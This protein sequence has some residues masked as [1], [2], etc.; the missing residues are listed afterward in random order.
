M[1]KYKNTEEQ[2]R[3]ITL[4]GLATAAVF[5]FTFFLKLPGINGYVHLGD[6]AIFITSVILPLPYSALA[7]MLGAGLADLCGGYVL[8]FPF[9]AVI[10]A[11]M[12]LPFRANTKRIM[13]KRNIVALVTAVAMNA[14][15]YYLG[16][17]VI[18]RN[19]I[20]PIAEIPGNLAQG[21]CGAVIFCAV[22]A[23][24]DAKPHLRDLI[25]HKKDR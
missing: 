15:G 21:V 17:A 23:F 10:K 20:A 16:G 8:W 2:I 1:G 11:L 9:T 24:V 19:F 13:S 3:H 6:A 12:T 14:L 7:A 22:G 4:A 25:R 5:V 18:F